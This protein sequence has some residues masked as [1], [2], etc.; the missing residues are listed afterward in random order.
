MMA[1]LLG[2]LACM[3]NPSAAAGAA[4]KNLVMEAPG[5]A[6][7]WKLLAARNRLPMLHPAERMQE[8]CRSCLL[9]FKSWLPWRLP[10]TADAFEQG[11]Q[12]MGTWKAH[13]KA[14][15]SWFAARTPKPTFARATTCT[16][17]Q[18]P[19]AS[20]PYLA[21]APWPSAV[22]A[23]WRPPP[24]GQPGA[25]AAGRSETGTCG[26]AKGRRAL[27][28]VQVIRREHHA[29]RQVRTSR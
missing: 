21:R 16:A 3:A 26:S 8:V 13:Y 12:P 11:M 5:P 28:K 29:S 1:G 2:L 20:R 23:L 17:T 27:H 4:L 6:V 10:A 22:S 15:P 14:H 19:L 24:W 9:P 18:S 25:A 7:G